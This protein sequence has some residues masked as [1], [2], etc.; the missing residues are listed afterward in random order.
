MLEEVVRLE[1]EG[2]DM[3]E[4]KE[5]D[6]EGRREAPVE[7]EEEE[8]LII[9]GKEYTTTLQMRSDQNAFVK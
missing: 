6:G 7:V 5:E 9:G 2:E 1:V 3:L 4:G 8:E